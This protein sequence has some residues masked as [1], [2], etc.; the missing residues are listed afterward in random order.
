LN[1]GDKRVLVEQTNICCIWLT[2]WRGI[3]SPGWRFSRFWILSAWRDWG[4]AG[5]WLSWFQVSSIRGSAGW[6]FSGFIWAGV[7]L[8]GFKVPESYRLKL[9]NF[10][11]QQVALMLILVGAFFVLWIHT[12]LKCSRCNVR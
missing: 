5:E 9:Q 4:S 12:H 10:E 3:D 6:T 7:N 1:S 8:A 2:A 11:L